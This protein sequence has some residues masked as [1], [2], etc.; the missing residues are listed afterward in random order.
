MPGKY[1]FS[2]HLSQS[3]NGRASQTLANVPNTPRTASA[4]IFFK[5]NHLL[6]YRCAAPAMFF[7]PANTRPA[8]FGEFLFP[9]FTLMRK[10]MFIAGAA[11]VFQLFKLA[12]QIGFQPRSNFCAET[13]RL[14]Y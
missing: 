7:R 5:E 4:R 13:V 1:F 12:N 2:V 3:D 11:A 10:H 6:F 8:A 9:D 14:L